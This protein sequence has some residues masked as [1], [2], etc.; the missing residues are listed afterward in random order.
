MRHRVTKFGNFFAARAN[1]CAEAGEGRVRRA[2][3]NCRD[4]KRPKAGMISARTKAALA[5][6]K[7]RNKKLGGRRRKIVG[8]DTKDEPIYGAVANGFARSRATA[9]R[10][11]QERADERAA[12]YCP[13]DQSPARSQENTE[14]HCR[15][16]QCA[17]HSDITPRG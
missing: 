14:G 1:F 7:K 3:K 11:R 5:A 15:R 13:D 17:E 10:V 2:T 6:A 12:Q 8:Y 16:T 4:R 9:M